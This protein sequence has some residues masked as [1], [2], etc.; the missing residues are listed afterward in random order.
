MRNYI[1]AKSMAVDLLKE[2]KDNNK[3]HSI[4]N[5][6]I[7]IESK[8]GLIFIGSDKNGVLPFGIHL[9]RIDI[10]K[11]TDVDIGDVFMFDRD[12]KQLISTDGGK[13][14][15]LNKAHS[16]PIKLP[17]NRNL[18]KDDSLEILLDKVLDMNLKT[19]LD[20][21][22]NEVLSGKEP[23]LNDL[24]EVIIS[25]DTKYIEKKLRKVIGRGKGLTPSGD[26]MLIGLI[27]LNDI[28]EFLSKEFLQTV[29]ELIIGEELTTDVS[30]AY[31]KEA[32]EG[33]YGGLLIDLCESLIKGDKKTIEQNISIMIQ[34]GH[35][36]GIDT[37]TGIVLGINKMLNK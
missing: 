12:K 15:D 27:W 22:V 36:S 4:F 6:G 30:V 17:K 2:L 31:Y 3:V 8:N 21:M 33:K 13:V 11:I 19:G 34:L 32:F 26:D 5:N 7:N 37:L 16:Y 23:V 20:V 18:I 10:S 28:K 35:S 14:I 25:K 9:K 24:E 1:Y 29:E